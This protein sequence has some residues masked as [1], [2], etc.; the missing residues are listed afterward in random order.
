MR[1]LTP[2]RVSSQAAKSPAGPLPTIRTE[3]FEAGS[4]ILAAFAIASTLPR[5]GPSIKDG[6]GRSERSLPFDHP[7]CHSRERGNPRPPAAT[8]GLDTRFR[9]YD[10][11]R[12]S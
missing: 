12:W 4:V 10:D 8:T 7:T 5:C 3:G 1:G 9:G 6:G 2:W 11:V